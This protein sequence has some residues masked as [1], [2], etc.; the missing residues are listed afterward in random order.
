MAP[1]THRTRKDPFEQEWD[2]VQRRLEIDRNR[3]AKDLLSE[4]ITEHPEKFTMSQRRTLQRHILEWWQRMLALEARHQ[5]ITLG[6]D[7]TKLLLRMVRLAAEIRDFGQISGY[8]H[9]RSVFAR[10]LTVIFRRLVL[11]F[12]LFIALAL[13]QLFVFSTLAVATPAED[14]YRQGRDLSAKKDYAGSIKALDKAIS[15]DPKLARAY[16]VRGSACARLR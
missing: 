7:T 3:T 9:A 14:A 2:K 6:P 5:K 16:A 8:I 11:S 4:L 10:V 12:V 13:I 15:L 1:K